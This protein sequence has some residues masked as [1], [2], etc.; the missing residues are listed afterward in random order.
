MDMRVKDFDNYNAPP[1]RKP[2]AILLLLIIIGGLVYF[3]VFRKD[4]AGGEGNPDA[5]K[6]A[7]QVDGDKKPANAKPLRHKDKVA[8]KPPVAPT[9]NVAMMMDEAAQLVKSERL[10]EARDKY[11]EALDSAADPSVRDQIEKKLAKVNIT[12]VLS[13]RPMPEKQKYLVK[14]G[15]SLDRIARRY[16]TTVQLLQKSNMLRNPNRINIGDSLLVFTGKFSLFSS[17]TR[18][19]LVVKMNGKF[20]KRYKVGTGRFGKTPEGT[21]VIREKIKEPPWWRPDGTVVPYGNKKENILGTRWFSLKATG[22][23]EDVRGYGIHGTWSP[24]SVGTDSSAGCLR[25][26]NNEVEELF[27]YIPVGTPVTIV[28]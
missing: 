24:E 11:L 10:V 18:H 5:D 8:E 2:W 16:G 1:N 23:T 7:V 17:K 20:F 4:K 28:K 9:G 25:M 21:F 14:R 22:D 3:F 12:L 19:D 15:D 27:I 26:K 13:P 6:P